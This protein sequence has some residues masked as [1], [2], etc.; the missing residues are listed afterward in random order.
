MMSYTITSPTLLFLTIVEMLLI[1][2]LPAIHIYLLSQVYRYVFP[3][4]KYH[5]AVYWATGVT[6]LIILL[7]I[8][9]LIGWL[10]DRR[11]SF[12]P[13]VIAMTVITCTLSGSTALYL[14]TTRSTQDDFA[15]RFVLASVLV[16]LVVPAGVATQWFGWYPILILLFGFIFTRQYV[17]QYTSYAGYEVSNWEL[18]KIVLVRTVG[19][20][21]FPVAALG[22][23]VF[24]NRMFNI[25]SGLAFIH[26]TVV[27]TVII[28]I[29]IGVSDPFG[30]HKKKRD[31]I[32]DFDEYRRRKSPRKPSF[33]L[34]ISGWLLTSAIT[35]VVLFMLQFI[36]YLSLPTMLLFR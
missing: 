35:T 17:E 29:S 3:L 24:L 4:E 13:M 15:W 28:S 27:I 18:D 14:A 21:I 33:S 36:A 19:L 34:Y 2:P 10:T 9:A 23:L 12:Y 5:R 1:P 6:T 30:K 8:V 22:A 31:L 26:V 7:T 20:V 16:S 25:I 32:T 11:V